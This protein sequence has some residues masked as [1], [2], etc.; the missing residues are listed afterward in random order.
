MVRAQNELHL[1]LNYAYLVLT[2]A[3]ALGKLR[4]E[5]N[6]IEEIK[7]ALAPPKLAH[8]YGFVQI[9]LALDA[10]VGDKRN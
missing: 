6:I 4:T 9:D 7:Q 2:I 10:A 8:S 3:T 1:V 5:K